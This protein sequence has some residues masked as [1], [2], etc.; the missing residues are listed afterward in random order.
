MQI[1]IELTES[2][3]NAVAIEMEVECARCEKMKNAAAH[4]ESHRMVSYWE[5]KGNEAMRVASRIRDAIYM[6]AD[7][8]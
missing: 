1:T 4:S 3:A 6:E 8:K 2:E 5:E 7:L